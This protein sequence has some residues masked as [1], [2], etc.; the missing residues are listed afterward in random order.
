MSNKL[1]SKVIS[2]H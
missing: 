1:I 2:L